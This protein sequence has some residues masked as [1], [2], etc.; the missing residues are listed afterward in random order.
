LNARAACTQQESFDIHSGGASTSSRKRNCTVRRHLAN[1]FTTTW[2]H[3][4][5]LSGRQRKCQSLSRSFL[6]SKFL[7]VRRRNHSVFHLSQSV[8]LQRSAP[9]R[10]SRRFVQRLYTALHRTIFATDVG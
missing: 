8:E 10:R 6:Q 7:Q 1:R 3:N 2:M 5:F 9:R 4:G